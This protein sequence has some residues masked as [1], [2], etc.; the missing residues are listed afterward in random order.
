MNKLFQFKFFIHFYNM[1]R[2]EPIL[3]IDYLND[4]Y[5]ILG[6]DRNANPDEI[7]AAYRSKIKQYHP[8]VVA[9]AAPEIQKKAQSKTE[10]LTLAY[11]TLSDNNRRTAYDEKLR[12]FNQALVS[13]DGIPIVDPSQ[14]RINLDY[15]VSGATWE[16]KE[17]WM[18]KIRLHVDYNE[19]LF[20][21]IE[22]Q[23]K[24][25]EN[26]GPGRGP[27]GPMMR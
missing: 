4:H 17:E 16:E 2:F 18:K 7:T 22:G 13:E 26:P 5:A 3:G 11:H 9:R 20:N 23:Y 12:N 14:K 6:I 15:L 10:I 8:D 1:R 19:T 25:E 27:E 24:Q 21:V